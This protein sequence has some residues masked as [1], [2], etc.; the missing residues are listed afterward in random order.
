MLHTLT[1][2]PADLTS[3]GDDRDVGVIGIVLKDSGQCEGGRAGALP[4]LT[5]EIHRQEMDESTLILVR[6]QK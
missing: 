1:L 5:V 4:P 2:L 3:W 6:F